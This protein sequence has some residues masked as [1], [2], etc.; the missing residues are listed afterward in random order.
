MR[1]QRPDGGLVPPAR[2]IPVL[3]ETGLI[4]EAGQQAL[5]RGQRAYRELAARAG[6]KRAAHRGQRV[7][8]AAAPQELRRRRARGA[9][10]AS[11][12]TAAASTWR[13]P[14]AC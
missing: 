2:F 7:G 8:A 14:R 6:L 9:R 12:P 11:A 3:E 5:G 13:S 1:W 4:L 10:R